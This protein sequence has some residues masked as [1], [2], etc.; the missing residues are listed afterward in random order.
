MRF[1]ICLFIACCA[2]AALPAFAAD[3][4]SV[5]D[6]VIARENGKVQIRVHYPVTGNARVD[7]DVAAWARQVVDAFQSTYGEEPDLG[8]PYELETTYSTTRPS[9]SVL[10]IV[11]KTASYTGGAHGNLEISTTTYDMNSG[12]LIDLYDVFR[13]LDAALEHMSAYC[14]RTL[15][16]TLGDMYSEDMLR[17]GT[18]PDADNFSAFALTPAGIRIF[19][20]PY[21]VAPWAAG[22][23]V[24]DIPLHDLMDAGPRLSL[25]GKA[26]QPE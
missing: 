25:W 6:A 21:Q 23:Q 3:V 18:A 2:L 24:V 17:G 20:Q 22:P 11:W 5:H 14:A 15:A 7:A 4:P 26:D 16:H 8:V 1:F 19:F 10:S 12:S 9:P 13:D